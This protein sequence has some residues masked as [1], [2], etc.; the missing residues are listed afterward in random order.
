MITA[1]WKFRI[2]FLHDYEFTGNHP[3]YGQ[4]IAVSY[5][6]QFDK[7]QSVLHYSNYL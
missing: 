1:Q 3:K 5:E 2:S 7:P 6:F 4:Y